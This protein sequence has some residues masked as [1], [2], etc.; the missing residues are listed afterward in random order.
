MYTPPARRSMTDEQLQ[1]ALGAARADESGIV[2]AME[3]LEAQSALRDQDNLEFEFWAAEIEAIGTPEALRAVANARRVIAGLE[4][5]EFIHPADSVVVDEPIEHEA[6]S[7]PTKQVGVNDSV[8]EVTASLNAFYNPSTSTST[9]ASFEPVVELPAETF[10]EAPLEPEVVTPVES[11]V[12]S[13]RESTVGELEFDSILSAE[14]VATEEQESRIAP[15]YSAAADLEVAID[16]DRSARSVSQLWP[17]LAITGGAAPI[18]VAYLLSSM[19]LSTLQSISAIAIGF[20]LSGLTLAAGSLAG[21]RSGLPTLLLSRSAFGVYGN[22]LPGWLI[23]I[24]RLITPIALVAITLILLLPDS[25]DVNRQNFANDSDFLLALA[26]S[27]VVIVVA[28]LISLSSKLGQALRFWLTLAVVSTTLAFAISSMFSFNF[29]NIDFN[30]N[31]ALGL[32]SL[33]AGVLIF[34]LFGNLWASAAADHSRELAKSA[35]GLFTV[36]WTLLGAMLVPVVLTVWFVLVFNGATHDLANAI[37]ASIHET[38][39]EIQGPLATAVILGTAALWL[40]SSLFSAELAMS[41]LGLRFGK[42]AFV[43]SLACVALLGG[44]LAWQ[45]IEP[46]SLFATQFAIL[47]LLSIPTAAW[48]GT[49]VSDVLLRRIAYHEVSLSRA[50]GFYKSVN[51]TNIAAWI[52][53]VTA[54]FGFMPSSTFESDLVGFFARLTG[55]SDTFTDSNFGILIA[56]AI[57][58]LSPIL[59]GIPRIKRQELEVL[60][61]EAR[62]DDLKD[63][64]RFGE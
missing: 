43:V 12:A 56:F 49:L 59:F 8:D 9:Q 45:S 16:R 54:G 47:S 17:W 42:P 25:I 46:S 27:A 53:A 28:V 61:I 20:S 35:R 36:L 34:A 7:E 44:A 31:D 57:A 22:Q 11:L 2:A 26:V 40:H 3:L 50:Y 10:V 51:I 4:A 30:A 24:Q 41:S 58:L 15:V 29:A 14:D 13:G 60:A 63:I 19:G 6:T 23:G 18:L 48:A 62:R 5:I 39:D 55:S 1:D 37:D 38:L 64:F 52:V 33:S 21:K 32:K